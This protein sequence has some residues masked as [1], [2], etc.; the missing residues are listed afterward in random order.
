MLLLIGGCT[1]FKPV[2][3]KGKTINGTFEANYGG[4]DFEG[5][6]SLSGG[7]LRMDVINALGFSVYGLYVKGGDVYVVDY[8]SNKRYEDLRFSDVDLNSYKALIVGISENFFGLCRNGFKDLVILKCRQFKG[9]Y[10]PV[11]FILRSKNRRLR[12][13]LLK[14]NVKG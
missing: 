13:R 14:V 6:F 3:H 5:F 8:Q 1:T 7:N 10:I 4:K 2:A 12:I 9:V 11:D